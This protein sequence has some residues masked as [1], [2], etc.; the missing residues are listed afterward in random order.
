MILERI[1]FKHA[2]KNVYL[3]A[4]A[5]DGANIKNCIEDFLLASN[6]Q[7]PETALHGKTLLKFG[8]NSNLIAYCGHNG[9]MEFSVDLKYVQPKSKKEVIILA[10]YSK[11]YFQKE[12]KANQS[13]PLVWTT[14]LMAP[15]TYTLKAAIDGWLNNETNLQIEERAAQAYHKYQK[16]GIKGARQLIT[17]GF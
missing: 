1:L 4:D 16:C 5:Y 2:T 9:L 12:L 8:G 14:H 11:E 7:N 15:E 10:C 6:G 17:T 3:L 13:E